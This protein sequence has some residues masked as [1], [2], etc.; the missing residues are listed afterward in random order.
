LSFDKELVQYYV[1][2]KDLIEKYNMSAG[3]AM[4]Q[5]GHVSRLIALRDK[6]DPV[7][8]EWINVCMKTI[9]LE[10]AEKELLKL[11]EQGF[12]PIYDKG[13]T[14]IPSGSLTVVGLP[15]MTRL[16]AKKYIKRLQ[17]FN[18]NLIKGD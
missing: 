2:N 17:L 13:L 7:F 14:E 15:T 12:L 3:K 10:G 9:T 4:A 16:E 6:D 8:Q 18:Y 5:V 11:I 1:I